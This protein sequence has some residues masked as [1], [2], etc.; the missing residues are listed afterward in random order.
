MNHS[1]TTCEDIVS[2]FDYDVGH[3]VELN[4]WLTKANCTKELFADLSGPYDYRYFCISN[5]GDPL[6]QSPAKSQTRTIHTT[7]TVQRAV[8]STPSSVS[9]TNSA[10]ATATS[11]GGPPAPTQDGA[12]SNCTKWHVVESGDGC[13]AIYTKYG[14]TSDQLFEW[15]TKISKDCSNIWLG[16]AVCVGV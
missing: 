4:P 5:T 10:P 2:E 16:Y 1:D 13:W 6:H 7:S 11:T 8:T 3:L 15:N 14:I 9:M 12:V